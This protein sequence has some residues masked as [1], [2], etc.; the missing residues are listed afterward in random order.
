MPSIEVIHLHQKAVLWSA[1]EVF[2]DY[3]E[4]QVGL[5]VEISVRWITGRAEGR[6]PKGFKVAL[7]ARVI[8]NRRVDIG[9]QMWLGELADWYG[10]GSGSAGD[11]DELMEVVTYN[12]TPDLKNRHFRREVGLKRFRDTLA[13][14]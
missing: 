7:D 13:G 5:P 10:T 2:N 14:A 9:S 4:M 11:D 6:D 12:E 1:T 8:T 3:G